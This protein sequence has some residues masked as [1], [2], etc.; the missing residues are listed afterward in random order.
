MS[1]NSLDE[2]RLALEEQFFAKHDAELVAKLKVSATQQATKAE[3]QKL[4]GIANSQLLDV[5]ASLNVGGAATLVMS[6]FPIVEVAWADGVVDA[7][8]HAIIDA[9]AK[10]M[11][12]DAQSP[13]HH[14]LDTWLK[15]KPEQKWHDLWAAYTKELSSKLSAS[16]RELLKATVL[17]RARSVAEISGGFL[18][19]AFRVSKAEQNVLDKLAAAFA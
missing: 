13:A 8:E 6:L 3:L 2:R 11:G 18:G 1:H 17:D 14:Y 15:E 5:L 9:L 16:D 4:T 10:A 19:L 7:K 12:V